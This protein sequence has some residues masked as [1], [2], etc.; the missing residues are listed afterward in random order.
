[1]CCLVAEYVS[2]KPTSE[3][4]NLVGVSHRCDFRPTKRRNKHPNICSEAAKPSLPINVRQLSG[5]FRTLSFDARGRLLE[6]SILLELQAMEDIHAQCS[7]GPSVGI[8]E[9]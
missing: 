7:P 8:V 3:V 4:G 2:A 1:M 6:H 5:T 9:R